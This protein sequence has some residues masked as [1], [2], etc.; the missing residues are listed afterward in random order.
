VERAW[1]TASALALA[2]IALLW[3]APRV[4]Q[5]SGRPRFV[6]ALVIGAAAAAAYEL[7]LALASPS[8]DRIFLGLAL[9]DGA[10]RA[11]AL[12]HAAAYAACAWGLWSLRGW[13]RW[14][15]MA[16]LAYLVTAFLLWGLRGGD[17]EV[18]SVMLWQMFVLP[19]LVFGF[20]YLQRGARFFR[21]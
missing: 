2:A 20:M 10:A 13:G 15:A 8:A 4:A 19:C 21:D 16:M 7:W 17:E 6:V 18:V 5:A 9:R 1:L 11:A 12:G 3:I 14:A